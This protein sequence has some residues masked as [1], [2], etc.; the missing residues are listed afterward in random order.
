MLSEHRVFQIQSDWKK[1]GGLE[2]GSFTILNPCPAVV[3][4]PITQPFPFPPSHHPSMSPIALY[5]TLNSVDG[6]DP[7]ERKSPP[8]FGFSYPVWTLLHAPSSLSLFLLCRIDDLGDRVLGK[9]E[10]HH[11]RKSFKCLYY[12]PS[13]QL[14]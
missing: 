11:P 6:S 7:R 3:W 10:I 5:N 9:L 4:R 13:S 2:L 1:G 12:G 14:A 8:P